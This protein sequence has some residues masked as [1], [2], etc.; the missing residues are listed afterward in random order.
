ME[1]SAIGDQASLDIDVQIEIL[2][3]EGFKYIE[4]RKI[5]KK[6]LYEYDLKYITQLR[7]KMQH[8]GISCYCISTDIGKRKNVK[9]DLK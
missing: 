9:Y 6:F 5:N 3:R 4:I 1:W 2:C 8:C 7:E